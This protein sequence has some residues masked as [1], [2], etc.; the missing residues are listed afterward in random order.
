MVEVDR[1]IDVT[2]VESARKDF[3]W[4]LKSAVSK[5]QVDL[6]IQWPFIFQ[7]GRVDC[8]LSVSTRKSLSSLSI[9]VGCKP[10]VAFFL[11]CDDNGSRVIVE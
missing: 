8:H 7:L 4:T 3:F 11:R 2:H 6:L 5:R 10:D 9:S 1:K